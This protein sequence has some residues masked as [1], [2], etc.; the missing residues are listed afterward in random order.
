VPD[1]FRVAR[2]LLARVEDPDTGDI[3]LPELKTKIP[4]ERQE[5]TKALASTVGRPGT[6]FPW[7]P[8]AHPEG[9]QDAFRMHLANAWEPCM[10]VT[11]FDGLP[12]PER[13]GNVLN[14]SVKL[15]L[16]FRLPPLVDHEKAAKAIKAAFETD[17][18]CGATVTAAFGGGHAA[19]GWN[20]PELPENLLKAVSE[21]C[22]ACFGGKDVGYL[23]IGGTIPLMGMLEQMFPDAAMLVTGVLGPGCNMHGPNECL[24]IAYTKKFT[25]AVAL[26][27]GTIELAADSQPSDVPLAAHPRPRRR[28]STG[29]S[30]ARFCFT[31]PEV[32]VGQCLCC[33]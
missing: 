32:P 33:L 14:A 13:A 3:L 28:T 29:S 9:E 5:Q 8:G 18:P 12:K 25:A 17:P 1:A 27:M 31:Q 2:R 19:K 30:K 21:A 6:E 10:T 24:P 11:G 7:R 4:V 15:S 16:S 20:A 26:V 22:R 23:G